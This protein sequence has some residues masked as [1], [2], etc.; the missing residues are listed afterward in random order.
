MVA[1]RTNPVCANCHK[2]MEPIGLALETFD[3]I[4]SYR[5][6]YRDANAEV[7]ASGTLFDSTEFKDTAE[8][9]KQ[10]FKYSDRFVQTVTTKM[11]TYA[12]GRAV[13]Y[14]DIPTVRKILRDSASEN[15]TWS[16][17]ILGIIESKP[18]QYRRS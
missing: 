17:L 8:F 10:L 14:N 16:S 18:F 15:Y 11:L 1:H 4:G 7:D 3:A 13:Q 2:M 9:Q 5:T 6:R 12:L